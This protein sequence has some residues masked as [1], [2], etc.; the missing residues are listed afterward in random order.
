MK[1]PTR[2][3]ALVAG[4]LA[5][6]ATAVGAASFTDVDPEGTF[7]PAIDRMS[8]LG[9]VEGYEDGSFQPGDNITRG[10]TTA[11]AERLYD[12]LSTDVLGIELENPDVVEAL[13]GPAGPAGA[14]GPA[15]P[16]GPAGLGA[17]YFQI[18]AD[19]YCYTL[20]GTPAFTCYD[21]STSAPSSNA[22]N[23]SQGFASYTVEGTEVTFTSTRGF[24]SCF[25][26]RVDGA[27][28]T[29]TRDNFNGNFPD[30]LW[31]STCVNNSTRTLEFPDAD[32]LEIRMVFGGE[33]DE[34]FNWEINLLPVDLAS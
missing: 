17:N 10:E 2:V 1:T 30:G 26:Y 23:I 8:D 25:E 32:V 31:E 21:S 19:T 33:S 9:I 3:A 20:A 29:D 14:T 18:D 22:A 34:R 27:L 6:S 16:A 7:G 5:L 28:P 24:P 13:T 4:A 15:G 11:I 12:E